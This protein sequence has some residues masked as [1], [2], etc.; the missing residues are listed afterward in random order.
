MSGINN[1][2]L[3]KWCAD[4]GFSVVKRIQQST[5]N[6]M[7]FNLCGA[8]DVS[9]RAISELFDIT[10]ERVRQIYKKEK[11]AREAATKLKGRSK[12]GAIRM[13]EMKLLLLKLK[14]W[15][16]ELETELA[17]LKANIPQIQRD[18]IIAMQEASESVVAS[19]C[20]CGALMDH[21]KFAYKYAKNILTQAKEQSQ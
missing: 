6:A 5:R 14:A 4:N 7:I 18:A 17:E 3:H 20:R 12:K 19:D 11:T 8:E 16:K 2:D 9:Q 13:R 10:T 21:D 1:H 15:N